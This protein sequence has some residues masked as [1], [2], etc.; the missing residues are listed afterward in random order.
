VLDVDLDPAKGINGPQSLSE[1]TNKHGA[2]PPTLTSKTPRGGAQLFFLLNG[3]DI[4]NSSSKIG[5]GLDI[6]GEGGY[7][8]LPPSVRDDGTPYQWCDTPGV[9]ADHPVEA[10]KWLIDAALK[11]APRDRIWA[12]KALEEECAAVAAAPPGTRNSRLN[13]AAYNLY[14]IVA[15]GGLNEQEVRDRL[16]KAAED[17]GL[18]ADDGPAQAWATINSG[19]QAGRAQPRQRPQQSRQTAQT[20]PQTRALPVI[21]LIEGQI[22]RA[23][24]EA[25]AALIAAGGRNLYQRGDLMVRPIRSKLK[26]ANNRDTFVWHLIPASKPLLVDNFTRIARFERWDK[27]A[28]DYVAKNCPNQVA[29][30]YLSRAGAWKLPILLGI[31]NTPFLRADASLCERPGYDQASAL[32]FHPGR[33]GFPAIPTAP[34]LEDAREALTYLDDSLLAEFPFVEKIDHSVALSGIL[35]ALDRRAM[36]TAPLHAFTSPVAGTGKSLLVDIA[37]VLVSGEPAPVISQGKTEEELEKRLGTALRQ[38]PDRL[39]R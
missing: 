4:R 34:T 28:N 23:V 10:P 16:F 11:K 13:A 25:E 26:A 2:L 6:R 1:L 38:R 20:Q 12:R 22:P 35:T 31:V 33:Q 30:I 9:T 15:G 14:Q 8:I 5:P 39:A 36:V 7:V 18:V 21:R 29:D 19:G 24:D 17:C 27:K 3:S 37:S 32:L